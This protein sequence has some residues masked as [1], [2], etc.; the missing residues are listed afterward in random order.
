VRLDEL[1]AEGGLADS[2]STEHHHLVLHATPRDEPEQV[3]HRLVHIHPRLG[4][5][6]V[7]WHPPLRR[8]LPSLLERHLPLPPPEVALVPAQ[9]QGKEVNILDPQ[10]KLLQR[11]G[12][13]KARPGGDAVQ[14]DESLP[15]AGVLITLGEEEE[16]KL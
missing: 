4:R 5:C 15:S 9:H 10:H 3:T 14:D 6:L 1:D 16:E 8:Q 13:V 7:E 12:L 2:A 11:L